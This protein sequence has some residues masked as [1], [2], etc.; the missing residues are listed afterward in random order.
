VIE[1]QP[2][3][4]HPP[5][6]APFGPRRLNLRIAPGV[7]RFNM[8]TLL[9]GS[10]FGIAM[11]SFINASQ[12]FI[13]TEV[14]NV[15]ADEQGPLAGNLTFVSELVVILTIGLIGALSDKIGRRLLWVLGLH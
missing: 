7:S 11:M 3:Q 15:P 4:E 13:F 8:F 5:G 14:L 9:F 10:F 1:S 12:P 6:G 2:V